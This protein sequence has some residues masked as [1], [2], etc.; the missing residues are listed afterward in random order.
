[1]VNCDKCKE[2]MKVA[3]ARDEDQVQRAIGFACVKCK[4]FKWN[5]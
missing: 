5:P 1:M 2:K 3:S 4:E